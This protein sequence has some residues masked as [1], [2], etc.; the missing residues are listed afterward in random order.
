[1][2]ETNSKRIAAAEGDGFQSTTLESD[3][4]HRKKE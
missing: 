1:M 3:R 4:P 2:E